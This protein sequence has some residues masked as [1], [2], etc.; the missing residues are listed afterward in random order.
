MESS[1]PDIQVLVLSMTLMEGECIFYVLFVQYALNT[2][3]LNFTFITTWMLLFGFAAI[4]DSSFCGDKEGSWCTGTLAVYKWFSCYN[5]SWWPN[6][7]GKKNYFQALSY[8]GGYLLWYWYCIYWI[9]HSSSL[10]KKNEWLRTKTY[11][12]FFV[13]C[14]YFSLYYMDLACQFFSCL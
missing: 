2:L 8:T 7:A 4:F 1:S 11:I 6:S 12:L 9:N 5:Y 10:F 14:L 13:S 3:V